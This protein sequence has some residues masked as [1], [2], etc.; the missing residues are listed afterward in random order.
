MVSVNNDTY[1]Q[2]HK[3]VLFE[4]N[5]GGVMRL[6]YEYV[7]VMFLSTRVTLLYRDHQSVYCMSVLNYDD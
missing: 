7:Q 5:S 6:C 4:C 3:T 2:Q 1:L